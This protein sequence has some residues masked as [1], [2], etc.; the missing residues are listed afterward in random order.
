MAEHNPNDKT[1]FEDK[2]VDTFYPQRPAELEHVCLH[3]FIAHYEFQ[4]IDDQ[5]QRVYRELGKPKLLNLTLRSKTRERTII[6]KYGSTL[7]IG[8]DYHTL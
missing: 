6:T 4:G 8:M 5:G 2:V 7:Y 3:D 1:I